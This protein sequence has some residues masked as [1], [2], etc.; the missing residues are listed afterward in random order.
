MNRYFYLLL[1]LVVI[2]VYYLT[3]IPVPTWT[4]KIEFCDNRPPKI[5]K[6]KEYDRPN[7]WQI[8]CFRLAVPKYKGYLNVCNITVLKKELP[9]NGNK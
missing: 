8:E 6:I 9:S 4:V 7:N 3:T 2:I 5:I 1:L